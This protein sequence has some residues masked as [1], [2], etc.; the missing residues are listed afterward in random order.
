[1][2]NLQSNYV[3]EVF[4]KKRVRGEERESFSQSLGLRKNVGGAEEN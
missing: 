2:A 1:M 3:Q 4:F